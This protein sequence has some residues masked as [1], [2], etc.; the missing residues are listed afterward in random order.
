MKKSN[1][2]LYILLLVIVFSSWKCKSESDYP[3]TIHIEGIIKYQSDG[4]PVDS[5]TVQMW[6]WEDNWDDDWGDGLYKLKLDEY[7]YTIT[8]TQTNEEGGYQ[9]VYNLKD[10]EYCSENGFCFIRAWKVGYLHDGWPGLGVHCTEEVQNINFQL[11]HV[12]SHP[13]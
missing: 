4:S 9:I 5:V 1:Y 2:I 12:D 7:M 8:S 6:R 3:R 11:Y 10:N 13:Q